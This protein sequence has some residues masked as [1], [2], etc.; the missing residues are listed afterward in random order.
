MQNIDTNEDGIQDPQCYPEDLAE[1]I[2]PLL[3]AAQPETSG[4]FQSAP[5]FEIPSCATLKRIIS[6]AY[7]ASLQTD[8][9]R[10]VTFRLILGAPQAFPQDQGPNGLECFEFTNTLPFTPYE[11]RK[12]SPA[13]VYHR[14][15]IGI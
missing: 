10:P 1:F 8:E 7:Q 14:S 3:Q 4:Q 5:G 12:L 9:Q 13:I 11:I 15:L 2:L 6:C